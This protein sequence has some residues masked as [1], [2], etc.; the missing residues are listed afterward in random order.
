[1][2][3]GR[4]A[5]EPKWQPEFNAVQGATDPVCDS[6]NRLFVPVLGAGGSSAVYDELGT[7]LGIVTLEDILE[8]LLGTAIMDETDNVSDL[9]RYAKQRWSRRLRKLRS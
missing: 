4:F 2:P 5:R 3:S 1:M 6:F 8:K 9:R 7:W